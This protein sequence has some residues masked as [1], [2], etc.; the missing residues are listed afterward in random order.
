M[1]RV[2]D[3]RRLI[4]ETSVTIRFAVSA[5]APALAKIQVSSYRTAYAGLLPQDYLDHFTLEEEEQDWYTLLSKPMT[6]LLMVAEEAGGAVIGYCLGRPGP[7]GQD[8]YDGELVA[9]HVLPSDQRHGAGR[10]LIAAMT[11]ALEAAGCT[12]VLLWTLEGNRARG[13][14]EHLGGK[15]IAQKEWQVDDNFTA[16]EVAYGWSNTADL[17]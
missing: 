5:D 3:L 13:F 2:Y 6:D 12:A 9:L 4:L 7:T 14:Y 11:R 8:G 16:I 10:A 15:L 17:Q 1:K